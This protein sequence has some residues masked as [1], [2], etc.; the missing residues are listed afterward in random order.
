MALQLS[1]DH[2]E[3]KKKRKRKR[4]KPKEGKPESLK[5]VWC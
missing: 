5:E 4:K 2:L 1:T 3:R